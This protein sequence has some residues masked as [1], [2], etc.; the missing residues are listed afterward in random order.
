MAFAPFRRRSVLDGR[1]SPRR[2]SHDKIDIDGVSV[3]T[4]KKIATPN[5]AFN[6]STIGGFRVVDQPRQFVSLLLEFPNV[7]WRELI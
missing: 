1:T 2:V 7:A 5:V 4:L 3:L 6:F